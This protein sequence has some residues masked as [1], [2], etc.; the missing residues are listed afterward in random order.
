MKRYRLS[1][2]ELLERALELGVVTAAAALAPDA[3]AA[4]WD[5]R[6]TSIRKATPAAELG[7]FYKRRAPDSTQLRV[8]GDPGMPVSISGQVFDTRGEILPRAVIEVWQ[9]N[10]LGRY[11]LDGYRYRA[12]LLSGADGKYGFESVMPGHYPD[13]VCQHVH[14]LVTAPG[15]K[16][17]TTQLYFATDPVFEGD[18]DKN[19]TRDPLITSRELV[20]PVVLAGDPKEIR[21]DVRFEL[22]LER[23]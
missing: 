15:H 22:V 2:R 4:A 23:L 8:P 3:L 5:E 11:D 12:R 9:T 18:P 16:P 1:R 21:A 6:E 17:L 20:R 19:F 7:P 13:R 14:Y 10:H